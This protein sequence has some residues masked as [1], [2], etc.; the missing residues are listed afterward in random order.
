MK[1]HNL[2]LSF[3]IV[4]YHSIEDIAICTSSI[5]ITFADFFE[6]EIIVS[7]NSMYSTEQQSEITKRWDL[8][9]WVFNEKNGGLPMQ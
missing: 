2:R 5:A 9:R 7:S 1:L 8:L 4:E 3:V 6:F